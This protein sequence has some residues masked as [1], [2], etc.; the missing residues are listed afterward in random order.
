MDDEVGILN[1]AVTG[2]E[3]LLWSA[4]FPHVEGLYPECQTAV[5]RLTVDCS[6]AQRA[7]IVRGNAAR[8][9][10]LEVVA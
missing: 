5:A 1:R 8:L 7:A 10:G 9:Y 6:K 3:P 2:V 4:D